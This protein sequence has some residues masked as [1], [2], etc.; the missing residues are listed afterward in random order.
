MCIRDS[1]L[2]F[3]CGLV[4]FPVVYRAPGGA[5][6]CSWGTVAGSPAR[7]VGYLS[8]PKSMNQFSE[9]KQQSSEPSTI[10]TDRERPHMKTHVF[11]KG[12]K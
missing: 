5:R 10:K 8:I 3:L 4:C 12:R 1:S 2:T 11:M 9:S 7:A 6:G